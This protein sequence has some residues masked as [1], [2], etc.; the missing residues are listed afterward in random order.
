M[1]IEAA[2]TALMTITVQN[3]QLNIIFADN[4]TSSNA[5]SGQSNGSS[6]SNSATKSNTT[7]PLTPPAPNQQA[8]NASVRIRFLHK[9]TSIPLAHIAIT[10][11]VSMGG[12]T[13][14]VTQ[15]TDSN[16]YIDY[17]PLQHG[18]SIQALL[19][20]GVQVNTAP[21]IAGGTYT[22][23]VSSADAAYKQP[24]IASALIGASILVAFLGVSLV[25][26]RFTHRRGRKDTP[27]PGDPQVTAGTF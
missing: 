5:S 7:T 1:G 9:G 26:Y 4:S 21:I 18:S 19:V 6:S 15:V 17:G 27:N 24:A 25:T 3:P 10:M 16:G 13:H 2:D 8:S 11:H 14:I 22:I 20:G 23:N 12:K